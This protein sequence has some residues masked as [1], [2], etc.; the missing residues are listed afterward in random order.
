MG[1]DGRAQSALE[2]SRDIVGYPP[3]G[4]SAAENLA[5]IL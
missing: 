2:F 3:S 5:L 1:V 4:D